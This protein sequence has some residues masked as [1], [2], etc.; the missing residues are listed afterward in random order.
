MVLNQGTLAAMQFVARKGWTL[1]E[2]AEAFE[3]GAGFENVDPMVFED[4]GI[5]GDGYCAVRRHRR[6]KRD[7]VFRDC[8]TVG[9]VGG[10]EGEL[11]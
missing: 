2:F 9:L 5:V 1:M 6:E 11:R 8:N 4:T 10:F 3:G 7:R